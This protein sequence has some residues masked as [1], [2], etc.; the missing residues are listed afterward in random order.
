[1]DQGRRSAAKS[2]EVSKERGS[3]IRYRPPNS[4][5]VVRL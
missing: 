4:A 3:K 1:M 5:G 2:M